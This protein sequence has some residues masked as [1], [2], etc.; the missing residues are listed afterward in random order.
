PGKPVLAEHRQPGAVTGPNLVLAPN[1]RK[2]RI[3]LLVGLNGGKVKSAAGQRPVK[4]NAFAKLP[5]PE[6]TL[7]GRL[8][9]IVLQLLVAGKQVLG[10]KLK[11]APTADQCNEAHC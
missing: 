9:F 2:F 5:A 4:P 11:K 7:R 1:P 10:N 8:F 6:P 3:I